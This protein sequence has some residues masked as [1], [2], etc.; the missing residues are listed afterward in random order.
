MQIVDTLKAMVVFFALPP[1]IGIMVDKY[2][3]YRKEKI[4]IYDSLIKF[5]CYI[6]DCPVDYIYKTPIKNAVNFLNKVFIGGFFSLRSIIKTLSASIILTTLAIIIGKSYNQSLDS[7]NS[8]SSNKISLLIWMLSLNYF[9]D[10]ITI[11]ATFYILNCLLRIKSRY[12]LPLIAA[13]VSIAIA[14]SYLAAVSFKISNLLS[15]FN[16][17]SSDNSMAAILTFPLWLLK[18]YDTIDCSKYLLASLTTFIPTTIYLSFILLLYLMKFFIKFLNRPV[19]SLLD[20]KNN[21]PDE[22]AFFT[23]I[24]FVIGSIGLLINGFVKIY[25]I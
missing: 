21:E 1:A 14:L 13:D 15:G 24:G 3:L 7:V 12:H 17:F 6:D 25:S 9:F 8:L 16:D 20:N 10:L 11:I 22:I 5:W 23:M 18:N 4:A 19:Y 2:V